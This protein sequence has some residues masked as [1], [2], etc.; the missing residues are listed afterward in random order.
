MKLRPI[1]LALVALFLI[2]SCAQQGV[3]EPAEGTWVVTITTEGAVTT[4]VNES[5]SVWGGTATLVEEAS[6]GVEFG[7]DPY[8]LG[9]VS[10]VAASSDH[11]YV[12]DGQVPALRVYDWNGNFLHDLGHEGE[13]PGEF[14]YP[15]GVGVDGAGRVWLHDQIS[16]RIVVFAPSGE[17][18]A[19]LNLGGMRISGEIQ[20]IVVTA[21]G[22]GYVFDIVRPGE[23]SAAQ[24]AARLIMRPFGIDGTA[25]EPIEIPRADNPAGLEAHRA[26][27]L[28]R[29]TN[30]PFHAGSVT[31]LAPTRAV[32]AGFADTYRFDIRRPADART[33]VE[34]TW[35]PVA[36]LPGE[37]AA[38]EQAVIR[39]MRDLSPDWV[40]DDPA[41]PTTKQAFSRFVPAASGEI[42]VVRPG[43]ATFDPDCEE[44]SYELDGEAHCWPEQR[45]I[46]VFDAEGRYL[47]EV[48]VPP[49]FSLEPWPFVRGTDVIARVEDEAGTIMV[50]RYRLVLPGEE[51]R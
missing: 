31:A 46:D 29:F 24:S 32:L 1:V 26:D 42:W 27:G 5:G 50:K 48:S 40:W 7:D 16:T 37:A 38:H 2:S 47:G 21:D 34:R 19:T 9:R 51:E 39:Y 30:V 22:H 17:V 12:I 10:S 36:V 14:R 20:S 23:S 6:I 35:N 15:T 8:M 18:A 43:P 45:I 3:V 11:I 49:D 28:I 41:I 44:D 13:G 33:V 4:V 25:G